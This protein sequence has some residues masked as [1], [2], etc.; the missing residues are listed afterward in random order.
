MLRRSLRPVKLF[1]GS[2]RL[3]ARCTGH[4][5]ARFTPSTD[6]SNS[7]REIWSWIPRRE[8]PA[9]KSSWTREAGT[10]ATMGATRKCTKRFSKARDTRKSFFDLTAWKEKLRHREF[11]QF[12]CTDFLFCMAA[13]TN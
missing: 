4:W 11:L 2:T 8:R 12:G 5:G 13:N 10:V 6:L 3:R 7:R 9:V 1:L